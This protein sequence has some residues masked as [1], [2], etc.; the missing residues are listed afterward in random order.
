VLPAEADT[1]LLL[2]AEHVEHIV[3][4][5]RDLLPDPATGERT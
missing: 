5:L 3:E 4:Q 2:S 1:P